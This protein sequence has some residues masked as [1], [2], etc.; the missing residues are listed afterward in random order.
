MYHPELRSSHEQNKTPPK[1][2]RVPVRRR[3][4]AP[5]ASGPRS[6]APRNR[7]HAV[8]LHPRRVLLFLLP[9]DLSPTFPAHA[10]QKRESLKADSLMPI[11]YNFF[12]EPDRDRRLS[13]GLALA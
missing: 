10:A 7:V 13:V 11:R 3:H 5:C 2:K 12:G 4:P 6:A 8:R 9:L 1:K